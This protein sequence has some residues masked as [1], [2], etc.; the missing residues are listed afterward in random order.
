MSYEF[1]TKNIQR[2]AVLQMYL[3][4]DVRKPIVYLDDENA[5]ATTFFLKSGVPR[6]HLTPVNFSTY[7]ASRIRETTRVT[8]VVQSID[9]YVFGVP[10]DSCGVVWLDYMCRTFSN[11]VI[12]RCLKV[13]HNVSV[14][15]S[16]RGRTR[17]GRGPR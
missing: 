2:S 4:H 10:E 15:L 3:S 17:S 9:E 6:K 12:Q 11:D 8:C 5:G 16:T 1:L 14:T 7:E 13:A